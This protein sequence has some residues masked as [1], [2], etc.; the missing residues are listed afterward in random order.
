MKFS[1]IDFHKLSKAIVVVLIA[2]FLLVIA[3]LFFIRLAGVLALS[4]GFLFLTY[5]HGKQIAA[6]IPSLFL[7]LFTK[8]L[9]Y[10]L[11]AYLLQKALCGFWQINYGICTLNNFNEI[12]FAESLA[13][14]VPMLLIFLVFIGNILIGLVTKKHV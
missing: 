3:N 5:F 4:T 12:M 2:A 1:D 13:V 11:V 6:S 7:S 8:N 10:V 9:G 14:F